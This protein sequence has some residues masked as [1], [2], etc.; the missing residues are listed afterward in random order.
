MIHVDFT[1]AIGAIKPLHS[2][3]N[4]A[5]DEVTCRADADLPELL[6]ALKSQRMREAACPI[7]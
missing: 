6:T 1:N 2:V 3:N 5:S 7:Y 4:G